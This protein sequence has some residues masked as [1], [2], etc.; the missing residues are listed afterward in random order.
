MVGDS[1]WADGWSS[2]GEDSQARE[3]AL[4]VLRDALAWRLTGGRWKVV[5]Q[6]MDA[7]GA[8]LVAGD[9]AAFREAVCDLERVGPVRAIRFEDESTVAAP[10]EPVRER[11]NELIHSLEN[12][13]TIDRRVADGDAGT[14]G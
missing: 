4:D 2:S 11:I 7:L 13:R 12:P 14:R 1:T 5:E 3:D 9:T 8:A 6:T 10:E